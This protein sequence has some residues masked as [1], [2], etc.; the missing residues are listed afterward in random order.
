MVWIDFSCII[1]F[2]DTPLL[3]A[4]LDLHTCIACLLRQAE[5]VATLTSW[6]AKVGDVIQA[7]AVCLL[8][9]VWSVVYPSEV[10][11]FLLSLLSILLFLATW[12]FSFRR[13]TRTYLLEIAVC[14]TWTTTRYTAPQESW[15]MRVGWYLPCYTYLAAWQRRPSRF[16]V[17]SQAA[18]V[19]RSSIF[20]VRRLSRTNYTAGRPLIH[21]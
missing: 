11:Y 17:V 1:P 10:L 12:L 5:R 6:N 16:P 14:D 21:F 15:Q 4:T 8:S 13:G 19:L 3:R 20:Q 2:D 9:E 18:V 7:S